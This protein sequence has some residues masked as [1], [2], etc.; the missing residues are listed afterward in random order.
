LTCTDAP[1]LKPFSREPWGAVGRPQSQ[2]IAIAYQL[3]VDM[4]W[5]RRRTLRKV[6]EEGKQ[7]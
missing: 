6:G 2:L 5:T 1:Q 4:S 3:V 7:P